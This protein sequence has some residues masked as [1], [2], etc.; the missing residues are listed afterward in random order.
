MSG[1]LLQQALNVLA[2]R[3]A[4]NLEL[5]VNHQMEKDLQQLCAVADRPCLECGCAQQSF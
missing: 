4:R 1:E 2:F 5:G 3:K